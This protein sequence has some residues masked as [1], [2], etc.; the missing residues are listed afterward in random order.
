MRLPWSR[1]EQ[2]SVMLTAIW[3][4]ACS[5]TETREHAEGDAVFG[6]AKCP[7]CDGEARVTMVYSGSPVRS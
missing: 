5:V 1:R 6:G 2:P 3:C 7:R 4:D